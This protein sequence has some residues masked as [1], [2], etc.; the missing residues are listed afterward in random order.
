M[1]HRYLLLFRRALPG[2]G[3]QRELP[4]TITNGQKLV[5]SARLPQNIFFLCGFWAETASSRKRSRPLPKNITWDEKW[6][7]SRER[8][9]EYKSSIETLEGRNPSARTAHI[10]KDLTRSYR[11]RR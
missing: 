5:L 8:R 9:P 2:R 7:G 10:Y 4:S 6:Y 3:V 1:N 11:G